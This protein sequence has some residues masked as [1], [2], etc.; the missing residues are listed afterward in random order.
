MKLKKGDIID[1]IVESLAFGGAGLSKYNEIAIFVEKG[2]PG[3]KLKVRL[4]KKYKNYFKAQIHEIIEQTP[5]L[6][7]PKC[8]HFN[9]CGGVSS[10]FL[11]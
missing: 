10:K 9:D 7:T 6:L 8:I 5:Y 3:Q 2:L 11:T 4:I 1:V